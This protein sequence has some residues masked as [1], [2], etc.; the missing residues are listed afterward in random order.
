M[1]VEFDKSFGRAIDKI[2]DKN[3]LRRIRKTIENIDSCASLDLV[4]N[5]KKLTGYKSF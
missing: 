5:C 4:R 2:H 3:V 1:T